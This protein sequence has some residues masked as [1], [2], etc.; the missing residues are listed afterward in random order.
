[1]AD[2]VTKYEGWDFL[3][4]ILDDAGRCRGAVAQNLVTMEIR[5]FAA[6]AVI[7]A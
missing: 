3:A 6:D 2:K 5:S 4:P 1:M 7:V